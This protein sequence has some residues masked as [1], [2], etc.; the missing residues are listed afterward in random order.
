MNTW[1][2]VDDPKDKLDLCDKCVR[3]IRGERTLARGNRIV[4]SVDDIPLEGDD[5]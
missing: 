3:Q 2:R 4:A 1:V 5:D